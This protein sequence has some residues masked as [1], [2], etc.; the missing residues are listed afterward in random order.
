MKEME[1]CGIVWRLKPTIRSM[2]APVMKRLLQIA[3]AL[4]TLGIA[5]CDDGKYPITGETCAPS[6]PVQQLDARDCTVPPTP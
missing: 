6:D 1:A 3:L 2:E 5:G 4:M